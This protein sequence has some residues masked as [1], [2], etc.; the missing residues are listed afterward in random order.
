ML[1]LGGVRIELNCMRQWMSDNQKN[2]TERNIIYLVSGKEIL[3]YH[4]QFPT[5]GEKEMLSCSEIAKDTSQ[6]LA[7]RRRKKIH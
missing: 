5:S 7:D 1:T 4:Y 3:K 2:D 6:N